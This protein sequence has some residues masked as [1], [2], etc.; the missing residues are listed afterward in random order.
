M[1]ASS[2]DPI[3]TIP[4]TSSGRVVTIA[5][6]TKLILSAFDNKFALKIVKS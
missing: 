1:S 3:P 2:T 4:E 5:T 6:V